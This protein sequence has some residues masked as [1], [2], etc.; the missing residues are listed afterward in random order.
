LLVSIFIPEGVNKLHDGSVIIRNLRI[1]KAGVFYPMPDS[2]VLDPSFG[3]RHRAALGITEETDAVVVVVSE[4]RGT[5]GFCFNGN[6]VGNLD[7]PG[8]RRALE[9]VFQPSRLRRKKTPSKGPAAS[10]R[11]EVVPRTDSTAP[12]SMRPSVP[13]PSADDP[14]LVSVAASSE[15]EPG[16]T[17]TTRIRTTEPE[18]PPPA[19]APPAPLRRP[20]AEPRPDIT[21]APLAPAVPEV[22]R[23]APAATPLRSQAA[24]LTRGGSGEPSSTKTPDLEVPTPD[25]GDGGGTP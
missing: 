21:A 15:R 12:P 18:A 6:I 23:L 3:S 11:G 16:E 14:T 20:K 8:L 4:E 5:I 10:V 7:G 19:P 13:P 9:G 22:V 17:P 25:S 1:A 24:P 2:R